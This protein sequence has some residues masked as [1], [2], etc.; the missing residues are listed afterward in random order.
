[1][2]LCLLKRSKSSFLASDYIHQVIVGFCYSHVP[3]SAFVATQN[4][5]THRADLALLDWAD[6]LVDPD[7]P[8]SDEAADW[9]DCRK[10]RPRWAERNEIT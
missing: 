9:P 7:W 5:P 3:S 10:R 2:L 4:Q 6:G 8:G 1:M